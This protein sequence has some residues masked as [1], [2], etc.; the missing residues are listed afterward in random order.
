MFEGADDV[1][2]LVNLLVTSIPNVS[3]LCMQKTIMHILPNIIYRF[4]ETTY[5]ICH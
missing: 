3:K 5:A 2:W 4:S 1:I